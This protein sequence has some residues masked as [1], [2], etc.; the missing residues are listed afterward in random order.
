MIVYRSKQ[1]LIENGRYDQCPANELIFLTPE[2][3]IS[4]HKKGN[5]FSEEHCRKLSESHKGKTK[6]AETRKKMSEAKRGNHLSAETIQ[7]I[8][9]AH[10][11]K[12]HSDEV[13]KK[14][15]ESHKGHVPWNK[16]KKLKHRV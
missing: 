14:L 13:R 11:G 5:V 15:S 3:H 9:E 2:E 4:L 7:K 10:L 1:E 16:G 12:R 8:R 6:S